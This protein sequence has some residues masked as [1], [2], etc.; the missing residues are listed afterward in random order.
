MRLAALGKSLRAAAGFLGALSLALHAAVVM[1]FAFR[2]DRAAAATMVPLW[3]WGCAGLAL[4]L[5]AWLARWRRLGGVGTLVWVLTVAFCADE[6]RPLA[7]GWVS[8]SGGDW[9]KP[10]GA[11]RVVT[12]DCARREQA[13]A[14]AAALRPD[15]VLMQER[16]PLDIRLVAD[17]IFGEGEGYAVGGPDCAVLSRWELAPV[18]ANPISLGMQA[19]GALPGG[20]YYHALSLHLSPPP[21]T[22][23][24]YDP[25]AWAA[26]RAARQGRR[27]ELFSLVAMM[28]KTVPKGE[29]ALIGGQFNAPPG[30]AALH[31]LRRPGL[32]DAFREAGAGWGDTFP[33]DLPAL[34]LAQIWA[35]PDLVPLRAW[36][37]PNPES[38]HRIVACD[39]EVRPV[40]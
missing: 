3:L 7:R 5:T 38:D 13:L 14:A 24:L 1:A 28:S 27:N 37:V 19:R 23:A 2:W 12:V 15:I 20:R 39:Y 17:V 34:R 33:Q 18:H 40:E 8:G 32:N 30:D 21:K 29:A 16:P 10:P 35:S 4:A 36:V 11:I 31:L 6:S 26:H 25:A 22:L 9:E